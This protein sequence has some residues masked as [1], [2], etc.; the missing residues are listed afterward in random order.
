M[1][2]WARRSGVW[3]GVQEAL[4]VVGSM[5]DRRGVREALA[6]SLG[7]MCDRRGVQETVPGFSASI[8]GRRGVQE[9]LAGCVRRVITCG[10]SERGGKVDTR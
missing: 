4:A 10:P 8:R 6:G 2:R 3:R 5:C 9:A 7:S 1:L